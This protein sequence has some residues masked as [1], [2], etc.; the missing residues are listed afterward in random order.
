MKH[1]SNTVL[2]N[3]R[4][5]IE[6]SV[7]KKK[8]VPVFD[9]SYLGCGNYGCVYKTHSDDVVLKIT[10]DTRESKFV[11]A[12]MSLKEWPEGMVQYYQVMYFGKY[13][14]LP[15]FGLWRESASEIG[16]LS[17]TEVDPD[18]LNSL[19]NC[20]DITKRVA[21]RRLNELF[22]LFFEYG[23]LVIGFVYDSVSDAELDKYFDAVKS[24]Y[25]EA[26]KEVDIIWDDSRLS[27]SQKSDK[28]D[29]LVYPRG[30]R[31][32][33][34]ATFSEKVSR[35]KYALAVCVRVARMIEDI[36]EFSTVGHALLFYIQNGILI[37]DLHF[38]NIGQVYRS[39]RGKK[40][41]SITDPGVVVFLTS[42]F[43]NLF[44]KYDL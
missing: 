22:N 21:K 14:S 42:R 11:I 40:I 23:N 26:Q 8:Y 15:M 32:P 44:G 33:K 16:E 39:D 10:S 18:F 1:I 19:E 13:S 36:P 7:I 28:L 20:W 24:A 9:G 3:N 30:R 5:L 4:E 43:D 12:A 6:Q 2:Q 37:N 27:P 38:G 34:N 25:L 29:I 41:W 31:A 17:D 35:S